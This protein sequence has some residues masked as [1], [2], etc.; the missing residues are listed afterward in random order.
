[1][2]TFCCGGTL[3]KGVRYFI[4]AFITLLGTVQLILE[5]E[6]EIIIEAIIVFLLQLGSAV[7]SFV[8]TMEITEEATRSKMSLGVMVLMLVSLVITLIGELVW[9]FEDMDGTA[10]EGISE[11][12]T[13]FIIQGVWVYFAFVE[14]SYSKAVLNGSI[15]SASGRVYVTNVEV[16]K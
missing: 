5:I 12:I 16:R 7:L 3:R 14:F 15:T 10:L 13:I 11:G 6:E 1:M 2:N 9:L 4:P 8:S